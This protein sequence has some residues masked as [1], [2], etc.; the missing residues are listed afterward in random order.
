[1]GFDGFFGISRSNDMV[2]NWNGANRPFEFT[3]KN[4]K[5]RNNE[6]PTL[7]CLREKSAFLLAP[8]PDT[9]F[10]SQRCYTITSTSLL[11]C[12]STASL[13]SVAKES[14]FAANA[15]KRKTRSA[16]K[17]VSMR[18]ACQEKWIRR[19]I[20]GKKQ[21]IGSPHLATGTWHGGKAKVTQPAESERT[22]GRRGKGSETVEK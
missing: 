3:T 15:H 22:T 18:L 20:C 2:C 5:N 21:M 12:S 10:F 13:V 8:F 9:C 16:V 1:M 19:E 17:C 7:R 14:R 6:K 4:A 11:I